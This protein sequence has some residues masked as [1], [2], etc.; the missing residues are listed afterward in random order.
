MDTR[1]DFLRAFSPGRGAVAAEPADAG[2]RS[3]RGPTAARRR[4]PVSVSATGSDVG[5][6]F[7]FIA[8]PGGPR[9]V[10]P[11]VPPRRI[12]RP[13]GLEEAGAGQAAG[14]AALRTAAG[15]SPGRGRRARRSRRLHPR[16][17]L[18]N[19]T[20][21]LRVPAYVLI[22]KGLKR[23]APAVV[24]LHDHGGFYFWGKEKIVEVDERAPVA[25]R[26]QA[27]VTTR[28]RASPRSW[29]GGATSSSSIDMFYWGERR[30]LL[31]DDPADWRDAAREHRGRAGRRVQ[32]PA[33]GRPSS[34]SAGRSTRRASPG[35]A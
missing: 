18:F 22:P 32:P 20:P 11:S 4:L 26:V 19:T 2:R 16:E 7:P 8:E 3:G 25:D 5:S 9:R 15:R 1:R 27:A 21:D 33:R 29:P 10:P 13:R 23:P 6:L 17:G 14:A 34:S 28:A 35:R 12:Q 31:D 24:A 30:M